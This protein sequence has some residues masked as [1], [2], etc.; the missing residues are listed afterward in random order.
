M[1]IW[2]TIFALDGDDHADGCA[3]IVPLSPGVTTLDR[4]RP[5]T[6]GQPDAPIRYQG[7][8]VLPAEQDPRGGTVDL[9]AIPPWITHDARDDAPDDGQPWPWLRLSVWQED[10]VLDEQ[11]A[12]RLRAALTEWLNNRRPQAG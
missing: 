10:A 7:S 11:Q 2:S 9:A 3:V 5:C 8:H 4:T 1:S 6:C 12:S